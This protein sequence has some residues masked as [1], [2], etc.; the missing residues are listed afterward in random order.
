MSLPIYQNILNC[1]DD[2]ITLDGCTNVAPTSGFTMGQIGITKLE[3]DQYIN[4]EY[5]SGAGLFEDKKTFSLRLIANQIHQ[6]LQSQY[7]AKTLVDSKRVGFIDDNKETQP[8]TG[9]NW[10]GQELNIINSNSFLE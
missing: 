4:R 3:L 2:I 7:K 5:L 10:V 1:F 6:H 9:T 8:N